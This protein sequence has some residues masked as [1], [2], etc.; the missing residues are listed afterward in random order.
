[1]FTGALAFRQTQGNPE[2]IKIARWSVAKTLRVLGRVGEA[3]VIQRELENLDDPDGFTLEEIA[4]C[5]Y[6]LGRMDEAKPYFAQA[7][8]RLSQIDWVAED[9]GRIQRL[10]T[11]S[12]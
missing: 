11:L 1:M 8:Q 9:V 6:A 7:H 4:E 2:N 12:N 3:L 5:L 10:E